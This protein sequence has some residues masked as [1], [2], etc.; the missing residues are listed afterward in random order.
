MEGS[1]SGPTV[2]LPAGTVIGPGRESSITNQHNQ[3]IQGMVFPLTTPKGTTTSI[4]IPNTDLSNTAKVQADI[5]AKV[6]AIMA[7]GG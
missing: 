5:A 1:S 4:F 3:V 2:N 7:I 6:Q